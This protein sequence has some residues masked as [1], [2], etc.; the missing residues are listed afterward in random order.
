MMSL[1]DR[2][3]REEEAIIM[4]FP[5]SLFSSDFFVALAVVA[6]LFPYYNKSTNKQGE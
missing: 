4:K 6:A 1:Q 5:K 2:S 3:V